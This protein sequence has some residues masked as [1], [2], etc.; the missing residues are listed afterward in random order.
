MV[1]QSEIRRHIYYSIERKDK[2]LNLSWWK[3]G[4]VYAVKD[5]NTKSEAASPIEMD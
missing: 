3:K 5:K 1:A 2:I 4:A